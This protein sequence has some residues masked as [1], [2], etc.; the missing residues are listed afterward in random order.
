M[1]YEELTIDFLGK[2]G[3]KD[4]YNVKVASSLGWN[5]DEMIVIPEAIHSNLPMLDGVVRGGTPEAA[6]DDE[7]DPPETRKA[8]IDDD[9]IVVEP[10]VYGE[11]LFEALFSGDVRR[12]YDKASS[13]STQGEGNGLR[14]KLQFSLEDEDEAKLAEIPWELMRDSA[15]MQYLSLNHK[16]PIVRYVNAQQRLDLQ[17][18]NGP[19]KV[20]V[21]MASPK[22]EQPLNLERERELIEESWGADPDV[23]VTYLLKATRRELQEKIRGFHVLH[24]MGHGMH[25]EQ[26]GGAIVLEDEQGNPDPLD[27]DRLGQWVRGES[28]RLVVLNACDTAKSDQGKPFASVAPRLVMAG[29]PA[30]IAMQF[31]ISDIAAIDFSKSFYNRLVAGDPVDEATARG[32]GAISAG[33]GGQLEWGTPVLFMRAP[34]GRLFASAD[35]EPSETVTP[36]P[37][38]VTPVDPSPAKPLAVRIGKWLVGGLVAAALAFGIFVI[39]TPPVDYR[40]EA[41]PI[42]TYIGVP[43]K[44]RFAPA[45]DDVTTDDLAYDRVEITAP[46]GVNA[47]EISE[48][49]ITNNAWQATVTALDAGSFDLQTKVVSDFDLSDLSDAERENV[50]KRA[51]GY[52]TELVVEVDPEVAS[53]HEKAVADLENPGVATG[54][55][56][57]RL[58]ALIASRRLSSDMTAKAQSSVSALAS[59]LSARQS[60]EST[61]GNEAVLL[62]DKITAYETWLEALQANRQIAAASFTSD[63][64]YQQYLT[65]QQRPSLTKFALCRTDTYCSGDTSFATKK[66]HMAFTYPQGNKGQ[67]LTIEFSQGD[68]SIRDVRRTLKGN[69]QDRRWNNIDA[70]GDVTARVFNADRDLLEVVNFR[71]N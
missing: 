58:E 8:S 31:P 60:A 48:T 39:I 29:V 25:S 18:L 57:S 27:A 19:L 69:T 21:A 41:N 50:I 47:L 40:F 16:T 66:I 71:I 42:E 35:S 63:A 4:S 10:S 49:S 24:Y 3:E 28:L 32:R 59:V 2:S 13:A 56:S 6:S 23:E 44:V 33:D 17:P 53:E 55:L 34:D 65:L 61:F 45:K 51:P 43:T 15:E 36:N 20:L 9:I 26:Y 11:Q 70:Q 14:I 7:P 37:I 52:T 54:D 64:A 38:P 62:R 1:N 67:T 30:V 12:I 5:A 22:G 68:R 46:R